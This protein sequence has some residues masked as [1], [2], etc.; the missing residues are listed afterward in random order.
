MES[1][2]ARLTRGIIHRLSVGRL[3]DI[4]GRRSKPAAKLMTR[5]GSVAR[6]GQKPT[7]AIATSTPSVAAAAGILESS[8]SDDVAQ[9]GFRSFRRPALLR[10]AARWMTS[11]FMFAATSCL[12]R[13]NE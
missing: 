11:P 1:P 4:R 9:T 5:H 10:P 8:Y 7:Q 13:A 12:V 2:P 3:G 6:E